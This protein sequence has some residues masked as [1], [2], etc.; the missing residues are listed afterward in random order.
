MGRLDFVEYLGGF[1][2]VVDGVAAF[3]VELGDDEACPVFCLDDGDGKLAVDEIAYMGGAEV[4]DEGGVGAV[5]IA[6][7]GLRHGENEF[8]LL[9]DF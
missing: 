3:A 5:C 9:D 8:G 7:E 4:A 2:V 6:G 1:G